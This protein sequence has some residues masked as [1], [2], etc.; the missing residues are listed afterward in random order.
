MFIPL[1]VYV[2][3]NKLINISTKNKIIM[4]TLMYVLT[5]LSIAVLLGACGTSKQNLLGTELKEEPCIKLAEESPALRKYGVG[6]HFKES[7]ARNIA[8]AQA[9]GAYARSM[10]SA[11]RTATEEIG[12][13]LEKYAGD[14]Q[15]GAS[16]RDQSGEGNDYVM[17]IAGEIV[18]NTHVIKTT[19]YIK[20]NNQF[21]IYV[22]IEYMGN[23]EQLVNNAIEE[24]KDKISPEDRVKLEERHDKFRQRVWDSLN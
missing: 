5:I 12:V 10:A 14:D 20:S 23:Q 19:R 21:R 9:R 15:Q 16:V 4:K 17:S 13:S 7:T 18:R 8:E 1:V 3:L 24:L 11:L 2:L 22:C 6:E